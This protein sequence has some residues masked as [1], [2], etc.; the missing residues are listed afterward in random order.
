M[1]TWKEIDVS[2]ISD[3]TLTEQSALKQIFRVGEIDIEGYS[4]KNY[5]ENQQPYGSIRFNSDGTTQRILAP[6]Q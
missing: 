1:S 2:T 3:L 4:P 5:G 6:W